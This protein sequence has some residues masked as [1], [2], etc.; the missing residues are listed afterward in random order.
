M[1]Y[2]SGN[3]EHFLQDIIFLYSEIR[4]H[5]D[6]YMNVSLNSEENEGNVNNYFDQMGPAIWLIDPF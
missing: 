6:L 5:S 2:I 3:N 4:T 1:L